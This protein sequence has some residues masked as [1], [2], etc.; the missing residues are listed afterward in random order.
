MASLAAVKKVLVLVPITAGS[1]PVEAFVPIAVLR[2]AGA[3]VTVAA[4]GAGAGLR[5]HAM[6]G[7][8]VVA[9]A[10]V[11]DCAD[12][13][14][15]LVALP[16]G[17]P[18]ADNLGGCAALESIVRRQALGGGLYAAI[19]AAPPLALARWGLLDGVK[20][21]AHPAFVDKFPAEV[22]AVDANVVV[23]GRVV[24]GRGPAPAME[25]AL[26]LVEQLYGK[27]KV[28]EIAKPMMVRYEPGYAFK[29]LNPVQW[30]CSGTPKVLIPVANG[31]DEMEVLVTVDVLRRANADVVVASAEGGD[32]EVV[33]VARHGTRIVA[34]AL[35]VDAVAAGQQF[36]FVV[37]PGGMAGA[38]TLA[39][40][41]ALVA[42]L[43]EHAAAGRAYGAI[44]AATAEVLEPH[45][46]LELEGK[47][48][49]TTCAS[50]ADSRECGSRVVVDGN[51]ATSSGPGT[52]MEFALAV[53]EKLLGAEAAREVAEALLFV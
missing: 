7:V 48:A 22:A 21:T 17:V 9:D 13:S 19:C 25:F 53:V 45:G 37:V 3:D 33:V 52:A 38:K 26:A 46:L 12:A 44:G 35:L 34:D 24:T 32:A 28:D 15:D 41:E 36:D 1:E 29:E 4:A 11:A 10:N 31:S 20:A 30:Q 40:T 51:L 23:D 27:D 50:M 39:G 18:G 5:V 14:Y 2:R 43:K 8:T 49:T 42:L 16:G 6:Y 47:K